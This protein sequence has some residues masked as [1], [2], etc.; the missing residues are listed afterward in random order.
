L[1]KIYFLDGRAVTK[2]QII[3]DAEKK[4]L[5]TKSKNK[6]RL[7]EG[8]VFRFVKDYKSWREFVGGCEQ[9]G[10]ASVPDINVRSIVEKALGWQG[11]TE[12]CIA[13]FRLNGHSF[14]Y[15]ERGKPVIYNAKLRIERGGTWC[16]E[17]DRDGNIV[18]WFLNDIDADRTTE[19][20]YLL[21]DKI[22]FPNEMSEEW[23]AFCRNRYGEVCDK[24]HI[25]PR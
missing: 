25:V 16:L 8:L 11:I 9:I 4:S 23:R 10:Y 20:E 24:Y 17:K 13:V 2:T 1:Q 7:R 19:G 15:S 3:H 18:G 12:P 21:T 6:R 22:D 5:K 14:V